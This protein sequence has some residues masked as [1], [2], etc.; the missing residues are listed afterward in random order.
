MV[1]ISRL[2]SKLFPLLLPGLLPDELLV[3]HMLTEKLPKASLHTDLIIYH[4][5]QYFL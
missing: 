5:L 3:F 4:F 2:L 1:A